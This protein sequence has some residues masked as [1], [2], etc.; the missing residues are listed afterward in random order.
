[1]SV[2]LDRKPHEP[3]SFCR[4]LFVWVFLWV[5]SKTELN[6]IAIFHM[7]IGLVHSGQGTRSLYTYR[8]FYHR[9]QPERRIAIVDGDVASSIA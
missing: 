7:V 9:D 1:M 6:K 8:S 5:S 2:P 4:L 3:D